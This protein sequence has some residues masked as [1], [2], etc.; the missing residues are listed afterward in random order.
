MK[1]TILNKSIFIIIPLLAFMIISVLVMTGCDCKERVMTPKEEQ[2]IK[3]EIKT[4]FNDLVESGKLLDPEKYMQHFDNDKFTGIYT[5][6]VVLE[7]K[8]EFHDFYET[9]ISSVSSYKS[10]EFHKVVI[11]VINKDVAILVNHFEAEVIL[12][13]GEEVEGSGAGTQVWHRTANGWK[14]VSVSGT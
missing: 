10:L 11:T 5:G 4:A 9:M 2:A 12:A 1:K 8:Q 3:E 13:S 6:G 14:L 7:S